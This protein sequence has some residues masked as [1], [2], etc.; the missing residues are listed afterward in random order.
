MILASLLNISV[1]LLLVAHV[2]VVGFLILVVMMQRPKQEG[3]GAAFGGGLAD[4]AWGAKTTDVL[5]KATGFLGTLFFVISFAL[6]ILMGQ[7]VKTMGLGEKSEDGASLVATDEEGEKVETPES[8][9]LTKALDKLEQEGAAEGVA[10]PEITPAAD[11]PEEAT[12]EAAPAID[13]PEATIPE[14][15]PAVDVPEQIQESAENAKEDIK[16]TLETLSEQDPTTKV[17]NVLEETKQAASEAVENAT[18][19]VESTTDGAKSAVEKAIE[20]VK[21]EVKDE[22]PNAVPT[23]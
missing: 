21:D 18:S 10:T 20:N 11:T 22:L 2:L 9:D 14:A 23:P 12:P 17:E 8:V 1:N 6:A 19:A 13:V 16:E 7:Q 4:A 3:L 15:T 5:Q